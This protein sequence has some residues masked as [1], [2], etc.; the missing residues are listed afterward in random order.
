MNF[1][2]TFTILFW[3]HKSKIDK[4][5]FA[6]IWIRVTVDG[7][8]VECSTS[9]RIKPVDWNA[10]VG[11]PNPGC[12]E[13]AVLS[14]YLLLKKA[15]ITKHYNIL[16]STK[17]RI[18]AEDVKN[19]Y[20]GI[21]QKVVMFLEV[22]KQFN[23][24]M[25]ERKDASDITQSRLSKFPV[26]YRDV[27]KFI[28]LKYRMSDLPIQ[29]LKVSFVNE[30]Y[31]HLRTAN[32]LIQNTAMKKIKD[33]RQILDYGVMLEYIPSNPFNFFKLKFV[34]TSR[35]KLTSQEVELMASKEICIPRLSE[36]RDCYLFVVYTGYSYKQ[37]FEL[38]PQN[39]QMW[40]DGRKWIIK[41]RSKKNTK[42]NV[43]LIPEAERILEKYKNHPYCLAENKLL[44]VNTNQ[45]YNAFLK[46]VAVICGIE[47]NLTTHT[48]RHT[49]ATT[50][51]LENGVP[52]ETV[53]KMLGH[54]DI[55]TTQIYADVTDTKI[56]EDTLDLQ[57]RID[58]RRAKNQLVKE[59]TMNAG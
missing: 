22:F 41:D 23:Q 45:N 16:L 28:R 31:H 8:R 58:Q 21:R 44:P 59:L 18:T 36:V 43:P 4:N 42:E 57:G 27:E 12:S 38:T 13:A 32:N 54:T 7:R 34:K 1:N 2:Q 14:E 48:A 11:L 49:F 9:R 52:L 20:K 26:L 29:D 51:T 56:S 17:E 24:I 5:G 50:T 46:E 10:N 6:P 25:A 40:I 37:L 15:E 47:K 30:F 55:R 19:S 3:L 53:S 39:V 35:T 33:L